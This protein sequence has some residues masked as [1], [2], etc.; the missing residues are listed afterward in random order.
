MISPEVFAARLASEPPEREWQAEWSKKVADEM[1]SNAPVRT[2]ELR[3]SVQ[4]TDEGAVATAP[5]AAYVE[6][7]TSRTAP[8]PFA[9]PSVNRLAKPAAADAGKR[10]I[11]TLT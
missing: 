11:E 4:A 10:V 1:R 3:N 6:Y 8:Q 2:G 7:G 9:G 5:Y